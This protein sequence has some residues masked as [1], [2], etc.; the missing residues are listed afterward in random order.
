MRENASCAYLDVRKGSAIPYDCGL[1]FVM[2]VLRFYSCIRPR[3]LCFP[4]AAS[5]FRKYCTI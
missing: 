3:G 4:L 1:L 5:I 2:G